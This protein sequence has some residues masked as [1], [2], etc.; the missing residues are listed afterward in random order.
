MVDWQEC[1]GWLKFER[2]LPGTGCHC[3]DIKKCL[4]V[5]KRLLIEL[6]Y[7]KRAGYFKYLTK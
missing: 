4:P 1:L 5:G 3:A 6:D 2:E 7:C